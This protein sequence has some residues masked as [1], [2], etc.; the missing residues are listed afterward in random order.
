MCAYERGC[1]LRKTFKNDLHESPELHVQGGKE[2]V[3]EHSYLGTDCLGPV[4]LGE[5]LH[6]FV[7][8]LL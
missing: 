4:A 3:G 1:G 5:S 2:K 8:A 7:T 6:L